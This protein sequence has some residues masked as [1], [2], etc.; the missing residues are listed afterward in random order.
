MTFQ[1][2]CLKVH[3]QVT[4]QK[5]LDVASQ[6]QKLDAHLQQAMNQGSLPLLL[7]QK[8]SEETN[9]AEKLEIL[10]LKTL[11]TGDFEIMLREFGFDRKKVT[12]EVEHFLGKQ[13]QKQPEQKQQV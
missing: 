13:I 8:A 12:F 6:V 9:L 1:G 7:D 4:H 2:K 3:S 5:E 10:A 11:Q